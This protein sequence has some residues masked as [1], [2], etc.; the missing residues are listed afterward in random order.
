MKWIILRPVRSI[1]LQTFPAGA[2][3][4]FF[5]DLYRP[6]NSGE[7]KE[8]GRADKGPL[9]RLKTRIAPTPSGY[10]HLGN[11]LSFALTALL[12]KLYDAAIVLRID[13]MDQQRARPEYVQDIFDTL[14][15][16]EL[17]WDEGPRDAQDF[18]RAYSQQHR[19]P[20]YRQ[21][22]AQ[23]KAGGNVFACDCSRSDILRRDASGS[24]T[25][26]CRER[27]LALDDA[28]GLSWRLDTSR[29][30]PLSLN[31]L[32]GNTTA[33]LPYDQQYFVIRKKDGYPAY[34]LTSL[35]D[36]LHFGISLIVR[37]ADLYGSTLA[38]LYLARVLGDQV[39]S[40]N[41]FYH[42]VLLVQPNGDKLSKSAGATSVRYL[43]QEGKTAADIFTLIGNQLGI[44]GTIR[45]WQEL[46][47]LLPALS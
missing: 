47:P 14:H 45:G 12:A 42:H 20:L 30:V 3:M 36:D 29:P 4:L 33:R 13:D 28:P 31:T 25:G 19:M 26:A 10:L 9:Q 8:T 39:F 23:L 41:L 11:V 21:A 6:M 17:P 18:S 32:Q 2:A 1:A 27:A 22:M 24:Y 40:G 38:Q 5:P 34:Q 44:H 46:L 7:N 15:F 43:R 37:G 35:V 16:L